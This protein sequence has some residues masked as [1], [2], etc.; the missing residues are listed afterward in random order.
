M[1]LLCI[2]NTCDSRG[3]HSFRSGRGR[4]S[5]TSSCQRGATREESIDACLQWQ[6]RSKPLSHPPDLPVPFSAI[7]T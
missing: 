7:S 3:R 5:T 4:R 1:A 2:S 6:D